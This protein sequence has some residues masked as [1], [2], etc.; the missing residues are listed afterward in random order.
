MGTQVYKI[1]ADDAKPTIEGDTVFCCT[2]GC[3][4]EGCEPFYDS[5]FHQG[6]KVC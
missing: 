2:S 3:Y 4:G 5:C 6:G 1:A